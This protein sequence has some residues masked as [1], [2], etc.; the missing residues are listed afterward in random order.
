MPHQLDLQLAANRTRIAL[1]R[2]QRRRVF[3][4][5]FEARESA[6]GR[7]YAFGHSILG[8][9]S[10]GAGFEH[11]ARDL[12]FQRQR[13]VGLGEAF[14]AAS[15]LK[16]RL[17]VVRNGVVFQISDLAISSGAYAPASTRGQVSAESS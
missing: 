14:S 8:Q 6:F 15:F 5:R 10:A 17:V 7:I 2:C 4:G 9:P 3:T 16:K 12:I 13:F 1:Q 11:L